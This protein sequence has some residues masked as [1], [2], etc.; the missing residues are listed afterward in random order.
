LRALRRDD[1]RRMKPMSSRS[2]RRTRRFWIKCSE[3]L[4]LR[5]LRGEMIETLAM[6]GQGDG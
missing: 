6:K 3:L 4:A 2:S 5:V 1:R